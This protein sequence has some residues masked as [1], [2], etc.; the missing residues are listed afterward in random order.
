VTVLLQLQAATTL[1][2][3]AT[4]AAWI[5]NPGDRAPVAN[6]IVAATDAIAMDVRWGP[7]DPWIGSVPFC[8]R[9]QVRAST[10]ARP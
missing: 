3:T 9:I 8:P 2:P 5:G 6:S 7:D 4:A 10:P 1:T